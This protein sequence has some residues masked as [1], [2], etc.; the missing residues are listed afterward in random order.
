MK[1]RLFVDTISI[2][3]HTTR[4]PNPDQAGNQ[5]GPA[6]SNPPPQQSQSHQRANEN[7]PCTP[8]TPSK[9]AVPLPPTNFAID[10]TRQHVIPPPL[11]E[12]PRANPARLTASPAR[13]PPQPTK[14]P[15]AVPQSFGQRIE[16]R[17]SGSTPRGRHLSAAPSTSNKRFANPPRAPAPLQPA[18]PSTA[19]SHS[20]S[21]EPSIWRLP[22][23][24]VSVID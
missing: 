9:G 19:P 8:G 24:Y 20:A 13:R 3:K 12:A 14:L 7:C 11:H 17:R 23:T 2:P 5:L 15:T 21:P 16:K 18:Q 6:S 10:P 22:R 1:P 4:G